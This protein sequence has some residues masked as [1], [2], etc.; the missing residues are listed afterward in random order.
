MI[1]KN[2][3]KP[4]RSR[5]TIAAL[6]S[7]WESSVKATHA[8]LTEKEIEKIKLC[9][10]QALREIPYLLVA[11]DD[12]TPV[13]FAGIDAHKLEM[14]FV[15]ADRRGQGVGKQL[16]QYAIG[17]YGINELTVNEQNPLAVG[18]YTHMGFEIRNRSDTDEQGNPYPIL[19]MSR[20]KA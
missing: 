9:V 3:E 12:G 18:F 6:L 10:P 5:E 2:I 1:I 16:L 19:Y 4:N 8:F 7:V 15:S 13:A 11:E 20:I 14:L 17:T